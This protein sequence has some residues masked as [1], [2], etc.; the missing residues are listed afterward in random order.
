MTRW[1]NLRTQDRKVCR[2]QPS[3]VVLRPTDLVMF[4]VGFYRQLV[5]V[6]NLK[7]TQLFH[8]ICRGTVLKD[9][10]TFEFESFLCR[11]GV[12]E[13]EAF[14]N[15]RSFFFFL[16]LGL[17]GYA[18][19]AMI[20]L[21]H[22]LFTGSVSPITTSFA[23]SSRLSVRQQGPEGLKRK[24]LPGGFWKMRPWEVCIGAMLGCSIK[25]L[26]W[27]LG[28]FV[29]LFFFGWM[30]LDLNMKLHVPMRRCIPMGMDG[31]ERLSGW[32][33]R[34]HRRGHLLHTV[35]GDGSE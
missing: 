4:H 30:G 28:G 25:A 20:F 11:V 18:G 33:F 9:Y 31:Q 27:L 24:G 10:N 12:L 26:E 35:A 15:S 34:G 29:F 17:K 32:P 14:S 5:Q 1:N 6:G 13:L 2:N 22:P 8:D 7:W 19:S 16:T 3:P 23:S 21:T